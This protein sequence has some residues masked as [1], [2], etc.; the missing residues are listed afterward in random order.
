M[1]S[2]LSRDNKLPLV[3]ILIC[4]YNAESTI[5][6]TLQSCINQTYHN[7]EILIHD[8]QSS[9]E[10]LQII[11]TIEDNRIRIIHSWKKLW[12]YRWLNFLLNYVGW[13]YI[14]IQDHDDIRSLDKLEKQIPFLENHNNYIGSGT[15][16]RMW[17]EWDDKYFDYY[18]G[19]ENYY[20][21]HPSLVFRAWPERYPVDRIYM[22]D[23][24]F[25]KVILCQ[26]KKLIYNID[27][28]LTIHRIKSGVNNYSYKWFQFTKKNIQT[29][30][31]LHSRWY[32]CAAL[33]REWLR[34]I[35]YPVLQKIW[36][37]A[38]IDK[39]E[40]FPFVLQGYGIKNY[41]G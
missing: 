22:N 11:K 10:T 39:I 20:T 33:C 37:W 9:D 27:E 7:I 15:K 17:Y 30:F 6:E 5:F 34:K 40:R 8:D 28:A 18:L 38:L 19:Q 31:A 16:T 25:Q 24:Y 13:K 23:A 26:W 1:S 14:A 21:I 3:S 32:A 12:P 4:T 2:D 41:K 29:L 35:L 36:K